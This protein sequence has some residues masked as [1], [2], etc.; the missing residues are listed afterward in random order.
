[1]RQRDWHGHEH[2]GFVGGIAEHQAL[3]TGTLLEVESLALVHA[4]A[5][6]GDCWPMAVSTVQLSGPKPISSV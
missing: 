5:M 4:W 3:V 1:M 6:S 2:V